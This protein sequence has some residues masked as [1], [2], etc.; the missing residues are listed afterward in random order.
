MSDCVDLS[1]L[2]VILNIQEVAEILR[3]SSTSVYGLCKGDPSFP[4]IRIGKRVII[5]R[6]HLVSWI[7][8]Q[9]SNKST[10]WYEEPF[11]EYGKAM[12]YAKINHKK[13]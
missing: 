5:P 8:Q 4:C 3:C 13:L 2:P 10:N 11:R 6:E 9:V 1:G 7:E 12:A